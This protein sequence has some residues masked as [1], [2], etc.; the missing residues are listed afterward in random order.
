VKRSPDQQLQAAI[1][2]AQQRGLGVVVD[3][4]INH[5]AADSDLLQAHPDWFLRRRDGGV[6]HPS[7]NEN[8]KR[9]VWRDLASFNHRHTPDP[10]GLF[11]YFSKIIEYLIGLGFR[12]FRCDAA[13]QLPANLWQRLIGSVKQRHPDILFLAETLGCTPDQTRRTAQAGFDYVF[14]SA[15]WWD[16]D[17]PWLME[18]YDLVRETTD[19]IAFPESHDTER[20]F[21]ETHGNIQAM[22]QRYLFTALF[23]A[24][25]MMP[26]GFEFGFSKRLHVTRT[27]PDDWEQPAIDLSGFIVAVN[28]IKQQHQ[29]FQHDCPTK[30][31]GHGNPSILILWK[32]SL[33]TSEE[34]LIILNK[35]VNHHQTFYVERLD[36][37]VQ[38]GR[39]LV[40]VS[41]EYALDYLPAPFHYDLRPGQS[42]VMVT[43]RDA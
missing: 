12:G 23:A 39:P 28:R 15:K 22:K 4:V 42:F 27:Q 41:P 10:E 30:V 26:I 24:G 7:C 37:L 33:D 35:D 21:R 8:G 6:E 34:A 20:L 36:D 18:Q 14:N 29:V 31:I 5:C 3:L 9:V 11:D 17:S 2:Y 19:S 13:Y 38:A 25:V 16:F 1:K 43:N 40:D 32:A